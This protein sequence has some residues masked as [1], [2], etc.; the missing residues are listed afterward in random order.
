MGVCVLCGSSLFTGMVLSA[1]RHEEVIC[2]VSLA[3]NDY[4]VVTYIFIAMFAVSFIAA[5]KI[6]FAVSAFIVF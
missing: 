6:N 1:H 5:V 2:G 4:H 3:F